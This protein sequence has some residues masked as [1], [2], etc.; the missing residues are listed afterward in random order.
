MYDYDLIIKRK[1]DIV[2]TVG[3]LRQMTIN[4]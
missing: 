1:C 3:E 2:N 4:Y